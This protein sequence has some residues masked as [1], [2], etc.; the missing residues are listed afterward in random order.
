MLLQNVD[1]GSMK[2]WYSVGFSSPAHLQCTTCHVCYYVHMYVYVCVYIYIS[3]SIYYFFT[4]LNIFNRFTIFSDTWNITILD[5][6]SEKIYKCI[7]IYSISSY[8]YGSMYTC[9]SGI[10]CTSTRN[11]ILLYWVSDRYCYS[12]YNI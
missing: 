4:I 12:Q 2:K 5:A 11:G 8:F 9:K 3:L 6:I 7:Y 1:N 10:K